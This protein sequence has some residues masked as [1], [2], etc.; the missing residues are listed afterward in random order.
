LQLEEQAVVV[1]NNVPDSV[2]RAFDIAGV[3]WGRA[4]HASFRDRE[5]IYEINTAPVPWMTDSYGNTIRMETK[6]VE[7]RRMYGL[8]REIDWGDGS[9]IRYRRGRSIWRRLAGRAG[10]LAARAGP[11]LGR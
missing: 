10:R 2:R 5:I 7:A 11:L 8:L 1:A 6:R 3:E 9:A 4:D